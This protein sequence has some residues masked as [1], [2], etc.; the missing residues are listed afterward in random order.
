M[1]IPS[2]VSTNSSTRIHPRHFR[3]TCR[4]PPPPFPATHIPRPTR[5]TRSAPK[6]DALATAASA[7][8]LLYYFPHINVNIKEVRWC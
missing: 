5:A 1:C 8:A 2:G 4:C 6:P 7:A 3:A